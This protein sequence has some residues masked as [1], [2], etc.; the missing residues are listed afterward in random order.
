KNGNKASDQIDFLG[1]YGDAYQKLRITA[2]STNE[3][4]FNTVFANFWAN[5]KSASR[6]DFA[7]AFATAWTKA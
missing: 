1:K 5:N 3:Q 2:G 7:K 6:T 4:K